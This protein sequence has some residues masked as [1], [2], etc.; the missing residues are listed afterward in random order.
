M[1]VREGVTDAIRGA[2]IGRMDMNSFRSSLEDAQPP[3]GISLALQALWWDAKGGW[4]RSHELAQ[5][6]DD[7]AGMR[8]HAY[9]HRKEGD[10]GNAAYWYRR[11]RI[12]PFTGSLEQEWEALVEQFL[13]DPA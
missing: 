5:Q 8:V 9:L 4:D 11:C 13:R 10:Q 2:M 7:A 1:R 3:A 12:A 6:R